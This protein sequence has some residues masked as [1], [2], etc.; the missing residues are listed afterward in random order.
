ML[1]EK[2]LLLGICAAISLSKVIL[3]F[4]F[5]QQIS[6]ENTSEIVSFGLAIAAM[7][8]LVGLLIFNFTYLRLKLNRVTNEGE[9]EPYKKYSALF[10]GFKLSRIGISSNYTT[11]FIL[12]RMGMSFVLVFLME[13]PTF[14]VL[15]AILSSLMNLFYIA[16]IQPLDSPGAN[17]LELFNEYM[18][19]SQ[20][21][22]MLAFTDWYDSEGCEIMK[23]YIGW[24]SSVF[25]IFQIFVNSIII[26]IAT[27]KSAINFFKMM[28]YKL[29]LWKLRKMEQRKSNFNQLLST[30]NISL[31]SQTNKQ[32]QNDSQ[33]NL[34]SFVTE[35]QFEKKSTL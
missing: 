20:S 32:K 1:I 8:S 14:Q 16:L 13:Y 28:R 26:L 17:N 5:F 25:L 21:Y 31:L 34:D 27:I 6:F 11:I 30:S 4:K 24:L 33:K 7:C 18:M 19:L 9:V 3:I 10:E 2:C 12:R 22:W 15:Y 23:V 35:T 29:R